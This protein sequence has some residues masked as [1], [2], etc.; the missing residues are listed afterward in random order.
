MY[1]KENVLTKRNLN[2]K[3]KVNFTNLIFQNSIWSLFKLFY[4]ALIW[5]SQ[6][7]HT[8]IVKILVEQEGIH[9]NA[10]DEVYFNNLEFQNNIW[11][12]IKMYVLKVEEYHIINIIYAVIDFENVTLIPT[13][14]Q[15][16]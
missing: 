3:D 8:E 4:T 13:S 6:N 1:T 7:G 9:N 12:L 15:K 14:T 16:V 11:N 5:A 10:K 2:A